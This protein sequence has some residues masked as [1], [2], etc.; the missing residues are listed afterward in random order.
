[1]KLSNYVLNKNGELNQC[2][3]CNIW[4]HKLGLASHFHRTHNPNYKNSG[5]GG[6]N[7]FSW[8]RGLTKETDERVAKTGL[9]VSKTTKG[10]PGKSPSKE[11]RIKVSLKMKKA[12]LEGRAWN[13]G[14]SRWNNQPSYPEKFFMIVIENEF[15]D[16]NYVRE[17]SLGIYSLDFAWPNKKLCIEIDGEQHKRF[18]NIIERDKRKDKIILNSGWKVLRIE[19]KEM[20]K[21][22]KYWIKIAKEFIDNSKVAQR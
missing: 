13:I 16:K 22:T 1:M 8:N 12:H 11:T 17:Y 7:K 10:K 14:K 20:Y 5:S 19:W 9:A 2:P 6:L 18:Q 4:K 21:D 15:I 3:I